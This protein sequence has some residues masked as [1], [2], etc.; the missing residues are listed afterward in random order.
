[1][2]KNRGII[3]TEN[4]QVKLTSKIITREFSFVLLEYAENALVSC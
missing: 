3:V 2:Q 4:K 1:M